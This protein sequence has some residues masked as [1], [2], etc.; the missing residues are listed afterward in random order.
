MQDITHPSVLGM[1]LRDPE[2]EQFSP[3]IKQ[4]QILL[5]ILENW[6]NEEG[7][8]KK[9]KIISNSTAKATLVS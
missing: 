5:F 2:K 6:A 9:T 1:Q 4:Q 7:K 3:Q 8:L